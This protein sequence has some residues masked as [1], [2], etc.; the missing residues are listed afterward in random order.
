MFSH[1]KNMSFVHDSRNNSAKKSRHETVDISVWLNI[2][3][4]LNSFQHQRAQSEPCRTKM[5][6][7]IGSTWRTDYVGFKHV[8]GR[9]KRQKHRDVCI[10]STGWSLSSEVLYLHRCRMKHIAPAAVKLLL[11]LAP[12][13]CFEV[14]DTTRMTFVFLFIWYEIFQSKWQLKFWYGT[15][16]RLEELQS[17]LLVLEGKGRQMPVHLNLWS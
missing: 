13:P 17:S 2:D 8:F 14:Y 1:H 15:T 3:R 11:L 6:R 16:E 12:W 9:L 4:T 7:C 5:P 10:R